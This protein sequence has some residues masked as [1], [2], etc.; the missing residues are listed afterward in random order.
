MFKLTKKMVHFGRGY[1]KTYHLDAQMLSLPIRSH[2]H[3]RLSPAGMPWT[4][5][6]ITSV[7]YSSLVV[8][9]KTM[10]ATTV[11]SPLGLLSHSLM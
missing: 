3:G 11:L 4:A 7:Y 5:E 6:T 8:V 9:T 10:M 1:A 2:V